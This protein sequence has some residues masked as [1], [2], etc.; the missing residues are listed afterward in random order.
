MSG[1]IWSTKDIAEW[2]QLGLCAVQRHV[3]TQRGFPRG[4]RPTGHPRG[5]M[6]WWADDVRA[7][8]REKAA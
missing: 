7:F 4:F 5:D 6:R 1:E 2:L 3:V 8:Y